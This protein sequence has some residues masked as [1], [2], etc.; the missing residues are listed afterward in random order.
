MDKSISSFFVK[1]LIF[2]FG[3]FMILLVAETAISPT[4]YTF[5]VWEALQRKSRLFIGPFYPNSKISMLEQGGL[6]YYT[7]FA[8]EKPVMWQTDSFGYR[9][10][11]NPM[12][13]KIILLGDSFIAGS[14]LD[15]KDLLSVR[16][17]NQIDKEVYNIAPG[18]INDF[19]A[20]RE[21]KL[22][23]SPELIILSVIE[24]NLVKLRKINRESKIRYFN[25]R[26]NRCFTQIA[27][28]VDKI[29][30][31][32][33]ISFLKARLEGKKGTGYQS[34]NNP[35]QYFLRKNINNKSNLSY[36]KINNLVDILYQYKLYCESINTDFLFMVIP[37]KSTI[38]WE[39]AG[40]INKPRN[41]NKLNNALLE[42]NIPF[43]NVDSIVTQLNVSGGQPYHLDDTH[44]NGT[45][46]HMISIEISK[47]IDRFS[48]R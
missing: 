4:V 27:T 39:D 30:R 45:S 18:T 34:Q 47:V 15:Q 43:I 33:S 1:I 16:L 42:A 48:K 14:S 36:T 8:V 29:L 35:N 44:W 28:V 13:P 46:T 7:K 5:R 19:I 25:F 9:N 31:Y 23:G 26:V 24:R 41:I 32:N 21:S 2:I 6:A 12:N 40:F 11:S 38:H 3:A 20:L 37:N 10:N 17:Q 22:F